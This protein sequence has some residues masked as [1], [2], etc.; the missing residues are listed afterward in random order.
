MNRP[1]PLR[2]RR[3]AAQASLLCT[4]AALVA[5]QALGCSSSTGDDSGARGAGG[6]VES[7]GASNGGATTPASGGQT[8]AAPS[9][10]G[11][12]N[13]AGGTLGAGG[14]S[15]IGSGGV[16]GNGGA[17]G[18]GGA[19]PGGATGSGGAGLGGTSD[20]AGQ[21]GSGGGAS[22][23][24][25]T[26]NGGGAGSAGAGGA[27]STTKF[28]GNITTN[29]AVRDGFA[30]YWNQIT[31]ENEGKWGSVQPSQGSFNWS[32]LDK[33]YA[34]AQ[35]N[36]VIF[37]EHNFVWGS[38]QPSWVN[39]GNAQTAVQA[40]MK[41]FCDRYPNTKLIDVV[42]EPPPHTTPA[43]IDGMG[44]AGAS[45]YDWIVNAFKWARAACPNAILILN[46]YNNIEYSNDNANFIDIVNKI[47]AAGAPIDAI[48]AQA[49]DAYKISTATVKTFIDK[50]AGTG[51]PVYIT[52][53]DIPVADDDMQK[54]IMQDQ[55][56]MY[57]NDSN[58]K[59]VTLWGYIVGATWKANTGIQQPSGAMRPAMT[60]LMGFLGRPTM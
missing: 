45:G 39:N 25:A 42:N 3:T 31:P 11:V 55:I 41:A 34:Y 60:W 54:S 15:N 48:G 43:Y 52:E 2:S 14:T 40:W 56:T 9:N 57:W 10:G 23:G 50:L 49:H 27:A 17:L 26:S 29:N 18:S 58:V 20:N 36:N 32:A 33:I 16:T 1:S 28:V 44:G 37:K 5:L 24:G 59:G 8:S 30:K 53:Y 35:S 19:A 21:T 38:Q 4:G 13:G 7:G 22:N 12:T 47:K 51:L 6:F 46:D